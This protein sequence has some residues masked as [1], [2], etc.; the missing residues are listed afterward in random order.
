MESLEHSARILLTARLLGRVNTL[1]PSQVE[2]LV[3]AR[4]R[5]AP[6]ATYPGCP[7]NPP[8]R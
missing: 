3:D 4:R 2:A 7:T 8:A 5:A 6:G 1:A